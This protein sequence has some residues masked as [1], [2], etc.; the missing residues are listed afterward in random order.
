[1]SPYL[2]VGE[3]ERLVIRPYE[4]DD[5]EAWIEPYQQR[6]P[7]Q[8]RH[9]DGWTDMSDYT[10]GMYQERVE[11]FRKLAE[12]DIAYI[13]GVFR[14]QDGACLGGVDLAT[15]IRDEFQ[16]ARMGYALHN[17]YWR[18][19]YGKEAASK[20]LDIAFYELRFHRVEVQI[21]EDNA[22][23]IG[24]AKSIGMEYECTRKGFIY[25]FNE[26]TDSMI[27]YKN[28]DNPAPPIYGV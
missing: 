14:K 5:Y 23:S 26:W 17:Q 11:R 15:L 7:S 10:Y 13:F 16:W 9:D 4:L 1:M 19:G 12:R 27:F 28:T 22:A 21:N 18:K 2:L 24:L 6:L 3:T 8:H 20:L 25:E